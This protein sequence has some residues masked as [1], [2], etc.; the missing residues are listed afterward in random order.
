MK[1]PSIFIYQFHRHRVIQPGVYICIGSPS[2]DFRIS[3]DLLSVSTFTAL[4]PS[5]L[6]Q[7]FANNSRAVPPKI[8]PSPPFDDAQGMLFQRGV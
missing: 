2:R 3:L 1:R 6:S 4:K 5:V 7:K 8:S